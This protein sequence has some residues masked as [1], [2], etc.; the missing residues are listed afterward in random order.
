M[1]SLIVGR[2]TAWKNGLE[3]PDGQ[4]EGFLSRVGGSA[5]WGHWDKSPSRCSSDGRCINKPG[6]P[7]VTWLE[8]T[9]DKSTCSVK[10]GPSLVQASII[11]PLAVCLS[12]H[13]VERNFVNEPICGPDE[14]WWTII[15]RLA[16]VFSSLA[17]CRKDNFDI[18]SIWVS[19]H[20][21]YDIVFD[22]TNVNSRICF[23]PS[24]LKI[25]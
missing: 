18:T 10:I 23:L 12:H 13:F 16:S 14:H 5:L 6:L 4:A 19:G 8:S 15:G 1:T 22:I 7:H 2:E 21:W 3:P 9:N 20:F 17:D 11:K 24:R 25:Q